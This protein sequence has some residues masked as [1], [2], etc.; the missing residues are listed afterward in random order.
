MPAWGDIRSAVLPC[1]SAAAASL[2]GGT[3]LRQS[4]G[5]GST[6]AARLA[7]RPRLRALRGSRPRQLLPA[8][9]RSAHCAAHSR[10]LQIM[11]PLSDTSSVRAPWC[12]WQTVLAL[13][14]LHLSP[15]RRCPTAPVSHRCLWCKRPAGL[16][17]AAQPSPRI[18]CP[19]LPAQQALLACQACTFCLT[20]CKSAV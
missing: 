13:S 15:Y 20:R 2:R 8:L 9:A 16:K 11:L 4:P 10:M 19:P 12:G 14:K 7:G 6:A 3:A 1:R 18:I 17:G 5:P